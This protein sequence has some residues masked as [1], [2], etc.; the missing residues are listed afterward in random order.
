VVSYQ[1]VK[2]ELKENKLCS[3]LSKPNIPKN[4]NVNYGDTQINNAC[5]F[6][7]LGLIIDSALSWKDNI[8]QTAIKLN[9]AGYAIRILTLVMPPDDF[10]PMHILPCHMIY[11]EVI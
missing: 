11:F 9:S 6:K 4:I 7:F 2:S 10:M 5:N 8:K 3:V 1:F